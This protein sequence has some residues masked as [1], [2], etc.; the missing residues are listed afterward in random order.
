MVRSSRYF[1]LLLAVFSVVASAPA[2]AQHHGMPPVVVVIEAAGTHVDVAR[3]RTA[4]EGQLGIPVI[5]ILES[6]NRTTLGTL[7]VAITDRG[8]HAAINFMPT[9]GVRY[10]VMLEVHATSRTDLH[11]EWLVAPCVSAIRTS[12][13]R[14]AAADP[15][16]EVLDPWL[17]S[18]VIPDSAGGSPREVIDPWVGTPRRRVRVTV[19]EYYLGEEILDPWSDAVTDYR[20]EQAERLSRPRPTTPAPRGG[21]T[22]P[23]P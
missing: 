7:A 1:G 17:A 19:S 20:D 9:D 8:R 23:S 14:R 10:A 3:V 11:G 4:M 18:R 5:S 13:E 21:R 16:R 6:M 12:N 22:A 2:R 15:P